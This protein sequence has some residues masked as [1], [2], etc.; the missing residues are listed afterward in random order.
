NIDGKNELKYD[1][2]V[3][4]IEK[5]NQVYATL[6]TEMA[7]SNGKF[8]TKTLKVDDNSKNYHGS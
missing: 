2:Y 1:W 3:R 8:N 7:R 5:F 4:C 6:I